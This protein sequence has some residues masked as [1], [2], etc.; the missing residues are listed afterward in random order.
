M[1][2]L[3]QIWLDAIQKSTRQ[4]IIQIKYKA[5]VNGRPIYGRESQSSLISC[6]FYTAQEIWLHFR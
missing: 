5:R 3:R 6:V 1:R 4:W 2:V